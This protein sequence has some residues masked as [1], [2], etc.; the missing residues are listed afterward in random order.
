MMMIVGRNS[1]FLGP[2]LFEIPQSNWYWHINH[3][4]NNDKLL[5]HLV[6]QDQL[7]RHR[8]TTMRIN[9]VL[10][11]LILPLATSNFNDVNVDAV[12]NKFDKQMCQARTALTS[13]VISVQHTMTG[14]NLEN[15]EGGDVVLLGKMVEGLGP[16][17]GISWAQIVQS[18]ITAPRGARAHCLDLNLND[19]KT[20]HFYWCIPGMLK[21]YS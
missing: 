19:Q 18:T 6:T 5:F 11:A 14:S 9:L 4:S 12:V 17:T 16:H 10:L 7:H 13:G 15:R 20:N 8:P 21:T 1:C 3:I 2:N